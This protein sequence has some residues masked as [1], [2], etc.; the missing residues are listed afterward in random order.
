MIRITVVGSINK[1]IIMQVERHPKPGETLTA[2]A[3]S[4]AFGGKGA[5]QAVAAA[6][7][8]AEV[9]IIGSVGEDSTGDEQVEHANG[10][11][12][13]RPWRQGGQKALRWRWDLNVGSFG[14]VVSLGSRSQ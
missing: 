1:D 4:S 13:R 6:R 2:A 3:V 12:T 9:T 14:H 7:L 8:G 5:N 11:Q 10:Q